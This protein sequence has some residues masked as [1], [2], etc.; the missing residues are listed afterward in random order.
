MTFWIIASGM[1]LLALAFVLQPIQHAQRFATPDAAGPRPTRWYAFL[2]IA[3]PIAA[4]ALYREL[5]APAILDAQPELQGQSHDADKMLAALEARLKK[6]PDDSEGW[7]VLGQAYLS[8]QHVSDAEEALNKALKLAPNDARILAQLAEIMAL[9]DKGDLQGRA[10]KLIDQALEINP[11]EEK[12]LELAGL[13]AFQRE[14]WA[15]AAFFWRH[16]LKRLPPDSEAPISWRQS[17]H[18]AA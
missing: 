2:L 3:L 11:D 12:A 14:E 10:R 15:Q 5:G 17:H 13:S 18:S 9:I 7:F 8:L 16:L 1:V 4:F 6:K